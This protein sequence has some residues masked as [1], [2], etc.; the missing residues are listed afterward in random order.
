MGVPISLDANERS[1]KRLVQEV[2]VKNG[3][4]KTHA[5][6][7]WNVYTTRRLL[8]DFRTLW[9]LKK[10]EELAESVKKVPQKAAKQQKV[11]AHPAQK[12]GPGKK[13]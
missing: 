12:K 10:G 1:L 4:L 7:E 11:Q 5:E 8:H 3:V 9:Q 2:L 13:R 6:R